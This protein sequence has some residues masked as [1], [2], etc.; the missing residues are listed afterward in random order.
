MKRIIAT[1]WWPLF[2]HHIGASTLVFAFINGRLKLQIAVNNQRLFVG[3]QIE[4][5]DGNVPKQTK[6]SVFVIGV[7]SPW[8]EVY[9]VIQM[10]YLLQIANFIFKGIEI[11]R[12]QRL[13]LTFDRVVISNDSF[14]SR[15]DSKRLWFDS[16][17]AW[18]Q[19]KSAFKLKVS[20]QTPKGTVSSA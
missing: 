1:R 13:W 18:H 9:T 14:V 20:N 5:F 4:I 10:A 16:F 17:E 8:F 15:L 3:F 19:S 7:W 12:Q 6:I 11:Q 2:S